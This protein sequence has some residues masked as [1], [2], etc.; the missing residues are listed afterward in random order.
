MDRRRQVETVK[1][2]AAALLL[3]TAH[4]NAWTTHTVAS[5]MHSIDPKDCEA[6][7]A[8]RAIGIYEPYVMALP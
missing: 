4:A 6:L 2:V 5:V 7:V 1:Y 8:S 3:S